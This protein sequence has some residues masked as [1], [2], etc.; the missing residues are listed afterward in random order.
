MKNPSERFWHWR[1]YKTVIDPLVLRKGEWKS[2]ETAPHPENEALANAASGVV[3]RVLLASEV[4]G[5]HERD[6]DGVA[7]E[8]LNGSRGDG[9]EIKRAQLPLQRQAH[10]H[11]AHL[12]Q[13]GVFK[14]RDPHEVR[15]LG[16]SARDESVELLGGARLAEQHQHVI[17]PHEA[18]VAVQRIGGRQEHRLRARGHQRL[19]ALLRHEPAL[20]H[21]REEDHALGRHA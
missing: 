14:R 5:L 9:R 2:N 17:R 15:A 10:M 7:E 4:L 19:S 16:A 18:D 11:V 20:P 1:R 3:K 8:H 21:A 12:P 6:G 13:V